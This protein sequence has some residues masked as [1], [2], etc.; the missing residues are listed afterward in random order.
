MNALLYFGDF[1]ITQDP[2][3]GIDFDDETKAV[4]KENNFIEYFELFNELNQ[5]CFVGYFDPKKLVGIEITNILEWGKHFGN[6]TLLK[7]KDFHIT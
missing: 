1:V 6:C 2:I 4:L 7:V 5:R 3:H